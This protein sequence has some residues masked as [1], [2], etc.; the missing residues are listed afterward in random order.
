M[1]EA[2]ETGVT[3]II[4][5]CALSI[6]KSFHS[7]IGAVRSKLETRHQT[8]FEAAKGVLEKSA[9][10]ADLIKAEREQPGQHQLHQMQLSAHSS[11]SSNLSAAQSASTPSHSSYFSMAGPSRSPIRPEVAFLLQQVQLQV[12]DWRASLVATLRL[13][14]AHVADW[15]LVP[16]LDAEIARFAACMH[17]VVQTAKVVIGLGLETGEIEIV[18]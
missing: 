15:P 13:C 16:G 7:L 2:S 9:V 4:C 5:T 11:S 17:D 8:F 12:A 3:R 18:N 10:L 14:R 6:T 1:E